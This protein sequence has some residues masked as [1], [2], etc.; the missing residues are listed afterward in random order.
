MEA[1]LE[2]IKR[3]PGIRLS[4][5]EHAVGIKED[6]YGVTVSF[7]DGSE[8][9]GDVLI[10]CDGVHSFT[11]NQHVDPQRIQYY[12]GLANA[13]GYVPRRTEHQLHFET[14]ALNFARRGL[15]LTSYYEHTRSSVY[16]GAIIE[17]P[18]IGSRDGW[19]AKGGDQELVRADMRERFGNS[20]HPTI[21]AFLEEAQD[22]YMWPIYSLP[23][24]GKWATD[25]VMLLGDAA[26]AMPPQGESTGII[27]EDCVLLARCLLRHQELGSRIKDAFDAYEALRRTRIN[28]AYK[29]SQ[30]VVNSVRDAGRIGHVIKTLVIPIYLWLSRVT[31]EK[32]FIEDVTTVP[33]G[34]GEVEAGPECQVQS[35]GVLK[36]ISGAAKRMGWLGTVGYILWSFLSS[37]C[38][39]RWNSKSKS[40]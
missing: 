26:H 22:W 4:C 12:T 31:R 23:P 19:R 32:H 18:D 24:F 9:S 30:G 2:A 15:L 1:L 34:G 16:I 36:A 40:V 8:S 27:L 39:R 5:D 21:D 6:D 17:T 28:A 29:E 13:F 25:R 35:V 11:R 33:L 7:S 38:G 37:R 20:V 10:G 3:T 14:S